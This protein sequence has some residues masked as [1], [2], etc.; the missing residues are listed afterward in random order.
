[1]TG[2]FR[3]WPAPGRA[4]RENRLKSYC[5]PAQTNWV[6]RIVH[7]GATIMP[8]GRG[9][10]QHAKSALNRPG[11]LVPCAWTKSKSTIAGNMRLDLPVRK[12]CRSE[13]PLR[14][15]RE[16]CQLTDEHFVEALVGQRSSD[17][18]VR[19]GG[20]IMSALNHDRVFIDL[21][22]LVNFRAI[23][24]YNGKPIAPTSIVMIRKRFPQSNRTAFA[25]MSSSTPDE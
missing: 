9:H 13:I 3:D 2:Q 5:Y 15:V 22:S 6:R 8:I 4:H 12:C 17:V 20:V 7:D 10:Q 14:F 24:R 18:N 25:K 23:R 16:G 19:G 1:M 21:C 11:V